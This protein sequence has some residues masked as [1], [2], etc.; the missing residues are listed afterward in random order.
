MA[1]NYNITM[2][3]F[4]GTDYD[5]L[6]PAANLSNSIGSITASQI[7]GQI[8]ASQ[9][10]GLSTNP[11]VSNATGTLAVSHGGTGRTSLTSGYYLVGNGTGAVTLQS[12]SQLQSSLGLDDYAKIQTGSYTGTGTYG[13]S[14]P[15]SLTFNFVPQSFIITS[16]IY[17]QAINL[18]IGIPTSSISMIFSVSSTTFSFNGAIL[19][20]YVSGNSLNWYAS[21]SDGFAGEV[22]S[23]GY[24]ENTPS[25][26]DLIVLQMNSNLRDDGYD[27]IVFG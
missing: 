7:S 11:N 25:T 14:N 20:S 15:N 24:T 3:Q 27:Y 12:P 26:S 18:L 8:P 1:T 17:R 9:I 23:N 4:N 22:D 6:Y 5:N 13:S 10:S 16:H 21:S 19:Y 2:K